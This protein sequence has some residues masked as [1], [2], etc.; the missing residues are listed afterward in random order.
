MHPRD[1]LGFRVHE[2]ST[3][4]A[5]SAFQMPFQLV[6][7]N[8]LVSISVKI[9]AV[10]ILLFYIVPENANNKFIIIYNNSCYLTH[11]Y[12]W[13]VSLCIQTHSRKHFFLLGRGTGMTKKNSVIPCILRQSKPKLH[14]QPP[15][16]L[17]VE[18]HVLPKEE[19]K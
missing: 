17:Q 3:L 18:M 1:L 6:F 11:V 8:I 9:P 5:A 13:D 19:N 15:S 2:Q 10:V 14:V 12:I 7:P 4:P 16:F